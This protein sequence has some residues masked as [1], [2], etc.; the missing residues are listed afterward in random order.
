MDVCEEVLITNVFNLGLVFNKPIEGVDFF[1]VAGIFPR[2]EKYD[3]LGDVVYRLEVAEKAPFAKYFRS[4]DEDFVIAFLPD[5]P[6]NK[7]Y[8]VSGILTTYVGKQSLPPT[9]EGMRAALELIYNIQR[10]RLK[11]AGYWSM[12]RDKAFPRKWKSLHEHDGCDLNFFRGPHFKYYFLSNGQLILVLDTETHYIQS[13]SFLEEIRL[14]GKDLKWFEEEINQEK[15]RYKQSRRHFNGIYFHYIV[16]NKGVPINGVD[17]R[18]ISTI[19]IETKIEG[20]TWNGTV[21]DYLK[22]RFSHNKRVQYLDPNQPAVCRN[23]YQYAPQLLHRHVSQK[24]VPRNVLNENT[25]LMDISQAKEQRDPH[26]PARKRWEYL[27]EELN[28][29]FSYL[30]LGVN[31]FKTLNPVSRH[32][33][34]IERP[35]LIVQKGGSPVKPE[36]LIYALRKGPFKAPEIDEILLFSADD[37]L[38]RSFW[39]AF[40]EYSEFNFG[41]SPVDKP[42]LLEKS[43][44]EIEN[45]LERRKEQDSLGKTACIAI[46][47]ED[48]PLYKTLTNLFAKY[49]IALQCL[50]KRTAVSIVDHQRRSLLEGICAGIF[51]KAGGIPWLLYDQLVYERYL[52]VDVGRQE[53]EWWAMGIV[54]DRQGLYD[55]L[56]GDAIVGED[57]SVE[58]LKCCTSRALKA[59]VPDSFLILRDGDVSSREVE[60]FKKLISEAN[61]PNSAIISIKKN[62]PHRLFR[63]SNGEIYKPMSGDFVQLDENLFVLCL[64][65]VDRYQHGT[66]APKVLEMILVSGQI[67]FQSVVRDTFYLSYL[68]WGSPSHGYSSP[69]PLKLA[70]V[71]AS[72]LSRGMRPFGPPF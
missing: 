43:E 19:Q 57:L 32:V 2:T 52:A 31:V 59:C 17:P 1:E 46:L 58:A 12:G 30:D 68:N 26:S 7:Q 53:A 72:A 36:N 9:E 15:E 70:H 44:I 71:L 42:T 60:I 22:L 54:Y 27:R 66:P 40:R 35:R 63:S 56:P 10:K 29:N 6:K 5:A 39:E 33:T 24:E 8:N 45:Y 18:P 61:V 37:S 14:R 62:V 67:N 3:R 13:K 50:R 41:W 16:G 48:S 23:S 34:M 38:A 21:Y 11:S 28:S 20:K 64:A 51:A 55:I 25:Y 69:A 65:G 4:K 47:D 49:G